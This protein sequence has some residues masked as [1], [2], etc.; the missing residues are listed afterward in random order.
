MLTNQPTPPFLTVKEV[1]SLLRVT[2]LT[3]ARMIEDGRLKAFRIGPRRWRI[4]RDSI[5]LNQPTLRKPGPKT[6][7]TVSVVLRKWLT[8]DDWR[9]HLPTSPGFSF[10]DLVIAK[11]DFER[12]AV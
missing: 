7:K 4:L 12:A 1:A 6:H 3:I 2:R 11:V 5:P 10:E 8:L 9:D